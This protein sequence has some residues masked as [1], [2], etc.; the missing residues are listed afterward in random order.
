MMLSSHS[1]LFMKKQVL[2]TD[3]QKQSV[4]IQRVMQTQILLILL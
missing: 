2:I 3:R 4:S 1:H